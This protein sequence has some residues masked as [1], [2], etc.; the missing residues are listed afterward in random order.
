M[1]WTLTF[2]YETDDGGLGAKMA[3]RMQNEYANTWNFFKAH[4]K[5]I[6]VLEDVT[7]E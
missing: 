6:A 4:G 5:V 7:V 1:K 3:D 2:E